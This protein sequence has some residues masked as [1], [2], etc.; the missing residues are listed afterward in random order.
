MLFLVALWGDD[1]LPNRPVVRGH[2]GYRS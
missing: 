2:F 1:S